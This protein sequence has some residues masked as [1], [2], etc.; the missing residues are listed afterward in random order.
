MQDKRLIKI[1]EELERNDN[2]KE[3]IVKI[4]KD[5][6]IDQKTQL[7]ELYKSQIN[8]LNYTINGYKQRILEIK[9]S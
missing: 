6:S 7:L 5:L 2:N 8:Y 4:I 1:Q 3:N 9:N